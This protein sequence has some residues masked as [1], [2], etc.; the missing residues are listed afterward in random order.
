MALNLL[1]YEEIVG[2]LRQ[3]PRLVDMMETRQ[4]E[5]SDEVLAWLKRIE[6][7]L[8]NNRL[9]AISQI[10][11]CRATLISA[12]R[13][14]YERDLNLIGRPTA[15]KIMEATAARVLTRSADLLQSV[16]A[17]RHSVFQ[18]AERISRQ[19]VAVAEAKGLRASCDDGR[20]HQDFLHCLQ[21]RVAADTDLANVYA[22]LVGLIGATDILIFLDRSLA[23]I[24]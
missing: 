12:S 24:S 17:E 7:T 11:S 22:H 3:V 15:R 14:A 16:I 13:G 18:E 6:T 5:F 9:P 21:Q 2:H 1:Q 19:I 4:Y 23:S 8:E 10:A 20:P